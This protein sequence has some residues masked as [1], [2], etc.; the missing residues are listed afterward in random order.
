MRKI[1]LRSE[2]LRKIG[3]AIKAM[4]AFEC[5]LNSLYALC[6]VSFNTFIYKL[7]ST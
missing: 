7:A 5:S 3:F 4:G 1:N 2:Q 6:G